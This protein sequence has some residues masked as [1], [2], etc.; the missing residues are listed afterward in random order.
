MLYSKNIHQLIAV[1]LRKFGITCKWSGAI[2]LNQLGTK[3]IIFYNVQT[4]FSLSFLTF[5]CDES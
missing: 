3:G 2:Q 1:F 5:T 4:Q